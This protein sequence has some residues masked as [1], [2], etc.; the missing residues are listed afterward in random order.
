VYQQHGYVL[1]RG[2][3]PTLP[4]D[5]HLQY[6]RRVPLHAPVDVG[7]FSTANLSSQEIDRTAQATM[8]VSN[9]LHVV[10]SSE[11]QVLER[12]ALGRPV[13]MADLTSVLRGEVPGLNLRAFAHTAPHA[14]LH[15]IAR[16]V[17]AVMPHIRR[18]PSKIAIS[19]RWPKV[20][21]SERCA[22]GEIEDR[23]ITAIAILTSTHELEDFVAAVAADPAIRPVVVAT[24]SLSCLFARDWRNTWLTP[25]RYVAHPVLLADLRP[26]DFLQIDFGA[27]AS[28]RGA[29]TGPDSATVRE[30]R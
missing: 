15:V 12:P 21:C 16:P 10:R 2:G 6:F 28:I 27:D 23:L 17:E 20:G 14:G 9:R 8:K 7:G 4:W 30:V 29:A 22:V 11:S 26:S 3:S 25:L 18:Q 5:G 13:A 1:A 24:V 19:A